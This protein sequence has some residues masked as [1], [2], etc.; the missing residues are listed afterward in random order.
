MKT[1]SCVRKTLV[2]IC[3][4]VWFFPDQSHAESGAV[5]KASEPGSP[6][7]QKLTL[8]GLRAYT[9]Q[10]S[11]LISEIDREY[12][13]EVARAVDVELLT[14]PELQLERT[15]TRMSVGGA[16]DPQSA[17]S[18]GQ[19]LRLSNFGAK[20]RVAAL[21]R[22]TGDREKR[23]KLLEL[24]Q[25]LAIQ[26]YTLYSLQQA[27]EFLI[28]AEKRSAKKV[29]VIKQGVAKGLLSVG[30]E[31]LFEG[32]KYLL[33][34]QQK[35]LLA[36]ISSV[37][38]ELGRSAGLVCSVIAIADTKLESLPS[39]ETLLA[40]SKESDLSENARIELLTQLT[41]EQTKL[42]E[43]DAYPQLTPKFV[44]QHTNDGGDFFGAG[45]SVS[46]PVWNRNQGERLRAGAQE[47]AAR[48]RRDFFSS[49]G[50]ESQIGALRGIA[51]NYAE[52]SE[53]FFTK[54]VPSF[55]SALESQERLYAQGKGNVLQVWQTLRTVNEV[56]L[57]ALSIWLDAVEARLKLS[58]LIG[59]EV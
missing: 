49:G 23:A 31:K 20:E 10:K 22:K 15:Y 44:Y 1:S 45:I 38:S 40:K 36:S 57:Q 33:Q 17:I 43:L 48:A 7:E 34:A 28:A 52:Q 29:S 50:L 6:C 19:P 13:A 24:N 42:A 25:R 27:Y 4:V 16:D 51:A 46:L 32:E 59:E 11:P 37:K 54:V 30:D 3:T 53:I 55:E 2:L 5:N 58:T 8:A 47:S 9:L 14:N 39:K 35:G 26:F 41:A 21:I 18:F 12:F 56:Q